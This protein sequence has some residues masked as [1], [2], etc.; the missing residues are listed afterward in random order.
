MVLPFRAVN[1]HAGFYNFKVPVTSYI[2]K[3]LSVASTRGLFLGKIPR[4]SS[5]ASLHGRCVAG[6]LSRFGGR[7]DF[8]I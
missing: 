2:I 3:M 4:A 7:R 8:S 1:N 6:E 5:L